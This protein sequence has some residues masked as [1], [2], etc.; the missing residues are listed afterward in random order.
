MDKD[1]VSGKLDQAK[2]KVKQTVGE[3]VGNSRLA[4]E[5]VADQ[6]KGSAKDT[7]GNVKDAARTTSDRMEHEHDA[8]ERRKRESVAESVAEKRDNVNATIDDYKDRERAKD[9]GRIRSA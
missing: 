3:A 4:N 1:R 7:W 9:P 6:V 8:A 5:G 2:G